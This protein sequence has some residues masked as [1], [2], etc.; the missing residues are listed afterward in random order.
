LILNKEKLYIVLAKYSALYFLIAI[1][2]IP[3]TSGSLVLSDTKG[4]KVE[5]IS[6]FKEAGFSFVDNTSMIVA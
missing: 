1:L 2:A 3:S 4:D 6:V 5:E